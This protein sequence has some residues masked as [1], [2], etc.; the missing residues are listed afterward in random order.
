[1]SHLYLRDCILTEKL[2]NSLF[3]AL[4]STVDVLEHKYGL[5]VQLEE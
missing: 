4:L 5:S 2:L 3:S 1:M